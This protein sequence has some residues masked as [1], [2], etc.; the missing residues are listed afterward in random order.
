MRLGLFIREYNGI[1]FVEFSTHSVGMT[2]LATSDKAFAESELKRF[3]GMS[4]A[5]FQKAVL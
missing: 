4:R 1:Y 5:E 2:L 3:Q